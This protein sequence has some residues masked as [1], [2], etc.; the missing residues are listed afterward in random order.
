MK[1]TTA[2]GILNLPANNKC[3][4]N[5]LYILLQNN[6][7]FYLFLFFV[8]SNNSFENCHFV[9]S[10]STTEAMIVIHVLLSFLFHLV[11]KGYLYFVFDYQY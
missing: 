7:I 3:R 5:L 11:R 10:I 1:I 9:K 4:I 6:L 2:Y 8:M